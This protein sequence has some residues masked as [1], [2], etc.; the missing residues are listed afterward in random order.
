MLIN[1]REKVETEILKNPKVFTDYS[2]TIDEVYENL[3]H[4][5]ST[6]KRRVLIMFEDMIGDKESNKKL[7]TELFLKGRKLNVL[8]VFM[9]KSYFKVPKTMRLNGTHY[10]IM[11]FL[12]KENFNK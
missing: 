4:Y 7:V 3:E 5:N 2:Q 11:K 1:G 12:I 6:N 8:L 9:W 10:F